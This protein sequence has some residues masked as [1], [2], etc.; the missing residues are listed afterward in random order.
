M[1]I[2]L[3]LEQAGICLG[4]RGAVAFQLEAQTVAHDLH[5]GKLFAAI[6]A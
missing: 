5:S 2:P 1:S 4:F 6:A 3:L